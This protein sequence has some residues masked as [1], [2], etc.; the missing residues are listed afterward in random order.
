MA[1]FC[2]EF[3]Y[4][5]Q[6]QQTNFESESITLG[7]DR[8]S[9]FILDHPTV[10]RQH[11]LIVHG[12]GGN[13]K[14]VV[15]SRGGLTAVDREPVSEAE[16]SL[17]DGSEITLGQ[18]TVRF[19]S[20][21]APPKP[22]GI[23]DSGNFGSIG[24]SPGG[25]SAPKPEK[26]EEK[27]EEEPEKMIMSWD[28]IAAGPEKD[29]DGEEEAATDFQRIQSATKKKKQESNP[30]IIIVALAGAGVLLFFALSGGG[31]G[32]GGSVTEQV[33]FEEQEPVVVSVSCL[34]AS[35]CRQEANQHY[36]RAVNLIEQRAIE[37]GN[38]FEGYH[39]LLKARAFLD[40]AGVDELPSE[41][42]RWHELHDLA[43]EDLD[44]RFQELRVRYHQAAQRDN[45]R[46][47]ANVLNEMQGFFP[48]RSARENR[49]ARERETE[50]KGRG[51]YPRL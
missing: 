23:G 9:D 26:K 46:E 4:G 51:I 17:Y 28:E 30:A 42:D 24:N 6:K 40:E 19:R 27:K 37:R 43:R 15:L 48:E 29:E 41:M 47:M 21:M 10:S 38:L 7:R 14:L 12:G 44:R 50:M 11:A 3:E 2:I 5:G 16:V 49:W 45:H 36:Q 33:P 1:S 32:G 25:G 8:S 34:D 13:F 35:A 22:G 18:Y 39:R 31:G 20:H